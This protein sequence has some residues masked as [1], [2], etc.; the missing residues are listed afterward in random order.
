MEILKRDGRAV[1]FDAQ[2]IINAVE[3]AFKEV[4]GEIKWEN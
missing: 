4:D 1:E 3:A 2:K